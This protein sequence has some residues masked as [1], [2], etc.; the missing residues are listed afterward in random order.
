M[1]SSLSLLSTPSAA[2][3]SKLDSVYLQPTLSHGLRIWWAYFWPVTILSGLITFCGAFWVRVLYEQASI[4]A[5]TVR[6]LMLVL[7][8]AATAAF[9]LLAFRYYLLGKQF[10]HFRVALLP[11]EAEA[12]A[13]SIPATWRRAARV[14]WTFTWRSVLYTII[15][16]FLADVSLG[17]I[18][19]LL[20]SMGPVMA[21]II[22]LAQNLLVGA[23]VGLFVIYSNV[24]DESFRDFRVVLLPRHAPAPSA[25]DAPAQTQAT[26]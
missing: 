3:T 13:P 4:D 1:P 19:G 5:S 8:Y 16:L 9:G 17:M 10:R 25:S 12:G 21:K 23:A 11:A 18:T 7:P 6:I 24:L 20:S 26:A 15:L 14:W 22:P 2:D